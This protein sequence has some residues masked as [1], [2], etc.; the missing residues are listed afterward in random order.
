MPLIYELDSELNV[1]KHYYLADEAKV[2]NAIQ[3]IVDQGKI[4]ASSCKEH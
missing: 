2:N 3:K 1:I 4:H